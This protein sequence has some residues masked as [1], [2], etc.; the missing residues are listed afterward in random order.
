VRHDRVGEPILAAMVRASPQAGGFNCVIF[1]IAPSEKTRQMNFCMIFHTPFKQGAF[2]KQNLYDFSY[3]FQARR[4]IEAE[5]YDFSSTIQGGA[6]FEAESSPNPNFPGQV[7]LVNGS[8][9]EKKNRLETSPARLFG[10]SIFG[11]GSCRNRLLQTTA[12]LRP[13]RERQ[14]L[15]VGEHPPD[16]DPVGERL[17]ELLLQQG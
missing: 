1:R 3:T 9:A 14:L 6:F 2:L 17:G 8:S 16:D 13:G 12:S 7:P 10:G 5:L 11:S 4:L 15:H